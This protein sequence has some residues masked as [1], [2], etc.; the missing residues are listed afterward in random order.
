MKSINPANGR[1]I[2]E[3]R[4]HTPEEAVQ[5]VNLAHRAWLDWKDTGF[6][7]RSAAMQKV[8]VLVRERKEELARLMTLEMGK[9]L[10]ESL[11]EVEKCAWVCEFYAHYAA[12]FLQDEPVE[13]D[14]SRSFITFQPL[15]IVLAVMPWNFPFWQV[16]R[17]VAPA[18]MAGN[19][20]VLKHA[21]NVSGC[22]LAIE[23]LFRTAGFPENLFRTLLISSE[24]VKA[25]IAHP[26]IKAITLTGSEFAGSEVASAAGKQVKKTVLELGG[27][28]PFIVLEDCDLELTVKNA[29]S[30]RL[31]NQGQSC[32]AAKRFIVMKSIL[33]E[34]THLLLHA[35]EALN[36]GDPLDPAT[37]V[38]PLARPDLVDDIDRQ[39]QES[40][41][42]GATLI[43]GGHRMDRSGCYYEP[44]IITDVRKGMSAYE[45]ETFGPLL[46]IIPVDSDEEAIAVANDSPFGLGGSVWTNDSVRG[47]RIA[48]RVETGSMFVNG[49]TKSDPRLPFGGIKRSGY[50]R[51]LGSYG[52]REFV[53]IKTVWIR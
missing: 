15:G 30:S 37:D 27:S 44:T 53:N 35:F 32:I 34:F 52:I 46:A 40:V 24:Q 23:D 45:E 16:F 29:V 38:G 41:D 5:I 49:I 48:R 20:G 31:I 33:H 19:G 10:R 8:A 12:R 50:G 28:D 25:V 2:R 14:A 39:V 13:S 47:E 51:E 42:K 43:V 7:Q 11:A 4:E 22:A 21:S 1:I 3:Y 17:F 9:I 18:L 6:P 36:V 26:Y